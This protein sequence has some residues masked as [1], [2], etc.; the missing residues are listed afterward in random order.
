M[1][2]F[3]IVLEESYTGRTLKLG[4]IEATDYEVAEGYGQA[5]IEHMPT[6]EH[7]RGYGP[8]ETSWSC[9]PEEVNE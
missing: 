1:A 4:V 2:K 6:V 5:F 3:R 8:Q 7:D 9:Y